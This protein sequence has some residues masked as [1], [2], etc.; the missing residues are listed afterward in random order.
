VKELIYTILELEEWHR[1][2][3]N[4]TCEFCPRFSNLGKPV[5]QISSRSKITNKQIAKDFACQ[6]CKEKFENGEL[7]KCERCGRLRIKSNTD[8][9]TGKNVCDCIK[10]KE[11]TE[12]KE[13]PTL[14]HERESMTSFYERQ[15]NTLR[16]EKNQLAVE[17]QTHL[18][19]MEAFEV[20]NKEHRQE[21][22][23]RI[24]ELEAENKKLKDSTPQ[25]LLDEINSLKEKVK[26][27]EEQL[28][29]QIEVP[30]KDKGIKGFFKFG[31][32]K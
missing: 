10:Y 24:K 8:V 12:E 19:A 25:E 31:G 22:L 1:T 18:D 16:E 28:T 20:W 11:D 15:I 26:Q 7:L 2:I 14:P 9:F 30:P 23:D 32:K 5:C 21:L 29:A 17:A 6:G 4:L 27:L 13:L 3:D